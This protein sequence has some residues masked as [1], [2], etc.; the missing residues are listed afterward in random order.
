MSTAACRHHEQRGLTIIGDP[1][2]DC[3]IAS[4]IHRISHARHMGGTHQRTLVWTAGGG[5]GVC[6][7]DRCK[8]KW[9]YWVVG[10]QGHC[11]DRL[12]LL[13][14]A[15]SCETDR[16]KCYENR[17]PVFSYERSPRSD[18]INVRPPYYHMANL[19]LTLSK[20]QC[21]TTG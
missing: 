18:P 1:R 20:E 3:T 19:S 21:Y 9:T 13:N 11:A 7:S 6:Y 17:S 2:R 10:Q 4:C 16:R 15:R 8:P 14:L 12:N 5:V